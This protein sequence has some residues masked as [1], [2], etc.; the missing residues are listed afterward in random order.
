M[1]VR[2]HNN[3][4]G[5]VTDRDQDHDTKNTPPN[6]NMQ[7]HLV[8]GGAVR[9]M[10]GPAAAAHLRLGRARR[11]GRRSL[12]QRQHQP[13]HRHRLGIPV[14][15]GF[16]LHDPG[17][18]CEIQ[19]HRSD[20]PDVGRLEHAE[21]VLAQPADID[22][23]ELITCTNAKNAGITIYTV[24]VNT[25]GDPT[26]DVMKTMRELADK[27][28]EIK[29]RTS[30]SAPSNRSASRSPTCAWRNKQPSDKQPPG[31]HPM[32]AAPG[33]GARRPGLFCRSPP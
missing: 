26:Q 25:G 27:F 20:H 8:P 14:V 15:D 29:R 28:T 30:S 4:N 21:P 24:Q 10:P 2:N 19:V 16:A 18:G 33:P 7:A 31:S 11:Q 3:W 32:A 13:G 22:A 9:L 12:S 23:R 17:E 5:C 6:I 1:D